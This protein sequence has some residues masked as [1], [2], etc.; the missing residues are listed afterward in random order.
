MQSNEYKCDIAYTNTLR[1][2]VIAMKRQKAQLSK[3]QKCVK[4]LKCLK[5]SCLNVQMNVFYIFYQ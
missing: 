4:F 2:T 5:S 3:I 1:Y